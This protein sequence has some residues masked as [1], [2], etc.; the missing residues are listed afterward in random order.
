[1]EDFEDPFRTKTYE[2]RLFSF[3]NDKG[4]GLEAFFLKRKLYVRT[5]QGNR[6]EVR[7]KNA[8]ARIE[9]WADAVR[10]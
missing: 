8:G 10:V 6:V 7:K 4:N 3:M 2:P 5:S 9:R 1:M